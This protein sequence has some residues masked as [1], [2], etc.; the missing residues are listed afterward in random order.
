MWLAGLF[1][2]TIKFPNGLNN[3]IQ[4]RVPESTKASNEIVFLSLSLGQ[5]I[6]IS[7]QFGLDNR[8]LKPRILHI[9]I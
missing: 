9:N 4:T 7:F 3:K 8:R 6:D 2:Q 5:I 1:T